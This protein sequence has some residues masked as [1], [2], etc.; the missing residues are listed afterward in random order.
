M[1]RW[2]RADRRSVSVTTYD[3]P[4]NCSTFSARSVRP[5]VQPSFLSSAALQR[6]CGEMPCVAV[7]PYDPT[8]AMDDLPELLEDLLLERHLPVQKKRLA[9]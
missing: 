4:F 5:L 2:C 9:F 3:P 1:R 6:T 7:G 8:F